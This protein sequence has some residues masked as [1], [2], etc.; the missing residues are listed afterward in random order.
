ML[1]TGALI[2]LSAGAHAQN[3]TQG[4]VATDPA[5]FTIKTDP[6]RYQAHP[7]A[8]S[9]TPPLQWSLPGTPSTPAA[10]PSPAPARASEPARR[11]ERP[12]EP[13]PRPSPTPTPS[14]RPSS[15]APAPRATPAPVETPAA[16]VAAAP[17]P[18]PAPTPAPVAQA[19]PA[20][21]AVA[22]APSE[23]GGIGWWP[24]AL[25]GVLVVGGAGF[26][27]GRR[28]RSAEAPAPL[29]LQT[30]ADPVSPPPRLSST[31]PAAPAPAF[32][33]APTPAAAPAAPVAAGADPSSAGLVVSIEPRQGGFSGDEALVAFELLIT[34]E[35][36]SRAEDIRAVLG[37]ITANAEQDRLISGF[38]SG[39]RLAQ[40]LDPFSLAPGESR[41]LS[42]RLSLP[43]D[44]L[45]VV[46]VGDRPMFVPIVLANLRW[47]AGISIRSTGAAFM[48]GTGQ[49]ERPGPFWLDRGGKLHDRLTARRYAPA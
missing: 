2:A 48:V 5:P 4:S 24:W 28:S 22:P 17:Q 25:A 45:N 6:G 23:S 27:L 49:G 13:A 44:S 40:A 36:G 43:S 9:V 29:A 11:A 8:P 7:D 38:H 46:T 34:N 20:P 32:P 31:T 19:T 41:R 10:T 37:M 18:A 16:P 26:F 12:A 30:V 47:R 15:T 33:A 35:G 42:G 21:V 1:G 3:S 39:A 14:A